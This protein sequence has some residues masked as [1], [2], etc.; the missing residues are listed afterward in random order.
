MVCVPGLTG[1]WVVALLYAL[2]ASPH[3]EGSGMGVKN[4]DRKIVKTSPNLNFLGT[5]FQ[6]ILIL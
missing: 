4:R 6:I 3:V 5:Y 2:I 1:A